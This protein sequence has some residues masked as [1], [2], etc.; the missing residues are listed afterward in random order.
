MLFPEVY[1]KALWRV[2]KSEDYCMKFSNGSSCSAGLKTVY[3][4]VGGKDKE[5]ERVLE[6]NFFKKGAVIQMWFRGNI[7][8]KLVRSRIMKSG[9]WILGP[10]GIPVEIEALLV[11]GEFTGVRV[12]MK[13]GPSKTEKVDIFKPGS[14]VSEILREFS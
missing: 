2:L 7:N 6:L 9:K 12:E 4:L 11:G 14:T 3:G 10:K 8:P 5:A 1:K 13:I